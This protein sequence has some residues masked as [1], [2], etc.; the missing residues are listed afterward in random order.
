MKKIGRF[1]EVSGIINH[2]KE[3]ER[4]Y[5]K[6]WLKEETPELGS[7]YKGQYTAYANMIDRLYSNP[8]EDDE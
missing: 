5:E 8:E 7:Y 4:I 3:Q 1:V 6:L 2:L